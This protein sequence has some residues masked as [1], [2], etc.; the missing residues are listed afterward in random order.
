MSSSEKKT[1]SKRIVDS[2][3]S[4]ISEFALRPGERVTEEGLA[5]QFGVSRTPVREALKTLEELGLVYKLSTGGYSVREVKLEAVGDLLVIWA[6]LED[7]AVE[8][9]CANND[10]SVFAGLLEQVRGEAPGDPI[11]D[12]RFHA[13][14]A[15]LSRNGELVRLLD[16]I[17][18]QTQ[19][20]RRLDG[21]NRAE[22][23]HNDHLRILE[24][25]SAG[26]VDEAR[27]LLK[28]HVEKT[29]EF[30]AILMRGGVHSLT[31]KASTPA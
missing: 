17:Y 29:H 15:K 21:L 27:R 8:L 10:V 3:A 20:Y 19:P 13:E 26:K 23:V 12:E 25:L 4:Q 30:I 7:L 16:S 31:F 24:L 14:L 1:Q 2:I 18:L 28:I 6:R 5:R 22:E 9:A 11:I